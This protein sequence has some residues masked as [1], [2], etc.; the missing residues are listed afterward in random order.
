MSCDHTLKTSG[1]IQ[2]TQKVI[3]S[4]YHCILYH[5]QVVKSTTNNDCIYV[6]IDGNSKK[7]LTTKLLLSVSVRELHNSMVIP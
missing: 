5:T 6:S 7:Q 4:I 3:E 1:V 2:K